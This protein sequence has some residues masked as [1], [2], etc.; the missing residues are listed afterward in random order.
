MIT[1]TV[2][3]V[4]RLAGLAASEWGG[5]C[6]EIAD[7]MHAAVGG[8]NARGHW[9]GPIASG[10]H[11]ASRRGVGFVQHSWVT[12][13]DGRIVDPTRWVFEGVEPY[14]YEG[15]ND[16]YDRG[17]NVYRMEQNGEPPTPSADDRPVMLVMDRAIAEVVAD[18][19]GD[20]LAALG[21][22][23]FA[24]A[25]WLAHLD[26]ASLDLAARPVFAALIDA[27]YGALIPIDNKREV[28]DGAWLA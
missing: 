21:A 18:A 10:S 23:S 24:Q 5:R 17:G 26:P 2:A 20:P 22:L 14:I 19:L 12:L 27:G 13:P 11:F 8:R 25:R 28:M 4:E 9:R 3:E 16:Y 1:I 7:A 15:P 6:S